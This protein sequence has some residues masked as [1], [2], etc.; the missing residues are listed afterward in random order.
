[1]IFFWKDYFYALHKSQIRSRSNTTWICALLL[2]T[3]WI[4]FRFVWNSIWKNM[5]SAQAITLWLNWR[6][7]KLNERNRSV[8][9][10][11]R[12]EARVLPSSFWILTTKSVTYIFN[13]APKWP[14]GTSLWCCSNFWESLYASQPWWSLISAKTK[15]LCTWSRIVL[16]QIKS[17]P[18]SRLSSR[19]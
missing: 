19:C 3:I 17:G 15:L 9:K 18:T 4:S 8:S 7:R 16:C 13:C 6:N 5:F 10:A 11:R 1:M 12:R 14:T 2:T